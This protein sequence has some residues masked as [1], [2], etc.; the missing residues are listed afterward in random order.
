MGLNVEE[1]SKKQ[2]VDDVAGL[3]FTPVPDASKVG[4]VDGES[5]VDAGLTSASKPLPSTVAKKE[6]FKIKGIMRHKRTS[7]SFCC[8]INCMS[9]DVA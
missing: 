7:L 5:K 9:V 6:R 2:N 4:R 1:G 8:K 3:S